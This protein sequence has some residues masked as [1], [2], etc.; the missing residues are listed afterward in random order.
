MARCKRSG[1]KPSDDGLAQPFAGC[2]EAW[3]WFARCQ[4]LR[5][6]GA[7]LERTAGNICRPCD[8]DDI[9]RAVK[10]LFVAGLLTREHPVVLARCGERERSPALRLWNE[11][12]DRLA[13]PL[14]RKGIVAPPRAT[15]AYVYPDTDSQTG[16][17]RRTG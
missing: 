5:H 7:R 11:A 4:H 6:Q 1:P 12:L 16:T 13:V 8:T 2:E 9:Y 15:D 17:C 3:F 10:A 14:V